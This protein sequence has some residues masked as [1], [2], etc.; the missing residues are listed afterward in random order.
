MCH[1]ARPSG[2]AA[3][4]FIYLIAVGSLQTV[5]SSRGLGGRKNSTGSSDND[6]KH[7]LA[8][9]CE[10]HTLAVSNP[11]DHAPRAKVGLALSHRLNFS[12]IPFLSNPALHDHN[13]LENS[14]PQV[15]RIPDSAS[16]CEAHGLE[17]E[18]IGCRISCKCAWHHACYTK[19]AWTPQGD[20]QD[21]GVCD[22]T[23]L[24]MMIT[25]VI[26]FVLLAKVVSTVR[27]LLLEKEFWDEHMKYEKIQQAK[28][29]R[30]TRSQVRR[31]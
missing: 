22:M 25:S 20:L 30:L 27:G 17:Q 16:E 24:F 1:H 23:V 9:N 14:A 18:M 19:H 12:G 3:Q 29:D 13:V 6:A 8:R 5:G 11:R 28:F 7:R 15:V 26:T 31:R 2:F 21:V 4:S 10:D